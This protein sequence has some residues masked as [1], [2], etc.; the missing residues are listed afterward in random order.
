MV[1]KGQPYTSGNW[2]VKAGSEE[3][4]IDRWTALLSGR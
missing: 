4:F 3:S 2:L 1:K